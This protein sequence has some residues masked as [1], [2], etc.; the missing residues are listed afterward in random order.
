MWFGWKHAAS[1]ALAIL[2]AGAAFRLA[3]YRIIAPAA[4]A[5]GVSDTASI[6]DRSPTWVITAVATLC[7]TF[8]S[9]SIAAVYDVVVE[10]P[11]FRD[12]VVLA[13]LIPLL[14]TP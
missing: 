7:C 13:A 12:H 10:A 1:R 11:N 5:N 3:A 4:T 8:V 6:L 9:G 14:L 2:R